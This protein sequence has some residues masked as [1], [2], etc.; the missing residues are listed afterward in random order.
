[1]S[2]AEFMRLVCGCGG[3]AA[4][5]AAAAAAGFGGACGARGRAT[6]PS[7]HNTGPAKQQRRG[8]APW[9][10]PVAARV[11]VQWLWLACRGSTS[12]WK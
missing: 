7:A 9:V 8:A 6:Q 12:I 2:H 11:C 5:A 1:M 10:S 4:A 3:A